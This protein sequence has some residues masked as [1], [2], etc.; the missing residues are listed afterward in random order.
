MATAGA[1]DVAKLPAAL[2]QA[3][4]LIGAYLAQA[5]AGK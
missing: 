5:R 1:K 2:Q 3:P 4:E